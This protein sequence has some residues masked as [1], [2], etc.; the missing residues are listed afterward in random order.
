M[1]D[2]VVIVPTRGRPEA[3]AALAEAFR[4]TCAADT[5]LVL[6]E[7]EDDERLPG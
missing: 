3:A 4:E 6:V 2:L 7:R 5:T 1:P